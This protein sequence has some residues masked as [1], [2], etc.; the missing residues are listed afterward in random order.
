LKKKTSYT[1][2]RLAFAKPLTSKNLQSQKYL[3]ETSA[4]DVLKNRDLTGKY[5]IVTGG[6][7]GL[8]LEI[9]RALAF[10]GCYVILA[11]KDID[12]GLLSYEKLKQE[13]VITIL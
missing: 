12:S 1:D 3:P 11:C 2:P 13:R 9:V 5:A 6:N 10:T 4:L 8:G 7:R